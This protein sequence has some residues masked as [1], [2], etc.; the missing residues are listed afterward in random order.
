MN[1][2]KKLYKQHY[3]TYQN[4]RRRYLI[5]NAN[6]YFNRKCQEL[7]LIPKYAR[8]KN[9]PYNNVSKKTNQQYESNRIANE[10]SFLYKKKNFL[11]LKLYEQE[12][13]NMLIYGPFWH[14]IKQE[15]LEKMSKFIKVKYDNLNKKIKLLQ[16][17]K[18]N[19]RSIQTNN[20]QKQFVNKKHCKNCCKFDFH[21]PV[22]NLS[23]IHFDENELKIIQDQYKSNFNKYNLP[24]ILD[25]TLVETENII[26]KNNNINQE[27][28]RHKISEIIHDH[29]KHPINPK[30]IENM[31]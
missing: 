25:N 23:T 8:S 22:K 19:E 27:L 12:L 2:N 18:I 7:H 20:K 1:F 24:H 31:K 10:I 13:Y 3:H 9:K 4:L 6:I 14:Q 26:R 16:Q 28:V 29:I 30:E 11:S 17:N 5:N 21:I 15:L